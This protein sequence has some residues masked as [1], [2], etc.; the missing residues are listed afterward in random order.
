M[1][2]PFVCPPQA[3]QYFEHLPACRKSCARF[4][5]KPTCRCRGAS[6]RCGGLMRNCWQT[7]WLSIQR[8]SFPFS[9]LPMISFTRSDNRLSLPTISSYFPF[10]I[11]ITS[12][13][14]TVFVV[15]NLFRLQNK[16]S[17]CIKQ[18]I[19]NEVAACGSKW[20]GVALSAKPI[21]AV[22]SARGAKKSEVRHTPITL[23]L[24]GSIWHRCG[25][26]WRSSVSNIRLKRTFPISHFESPLIHAPS[27]EFKTLN[28]RTDILSTIANRRSINRPGNAQSAKPYIVAT[29]Y[30]F[31]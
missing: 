4:A 31:V 9:R 10:E 13:I 3:G 5:N 22:P 28:L 15:N 17:V 6:A 8:L 25:S 30:P 20:S 1:R 14:Y 12:M 29:A 11:T 23:H 7:S 27:G 19:C 16:T 26:L 24:R 21:Q 2:H 18:W